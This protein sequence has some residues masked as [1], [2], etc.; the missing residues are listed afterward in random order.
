MNFKIETLTA[1]HIGSSEILSQYSDYVYDNGFVYYIDH[2]LLI[3]ELAKKPNSEDLLDRFISIVKS[4][5][6]ESTS[7]RFR[8]FNFLKE[9]RLD[10]KSC[11]LKKVQVNDEIRVEIQRHINT[12]GQPYIPGSSL[13]GAIRT[14]LICF[15]LSVSEVILRKK[16]YIG[17]DIFG[18][19]GEDVLK[20]LHVSDTTP[21]K[22]ENLAIAKFYK[23]NLESQKRTIPIIKEVIPKGSVSTFYIA[24]KAQKADVTDRFPFLEEG[25]E[26]SLLE[27]I[28]QY[29]TRNIEIEIEQLEKYKSSTTKGL[30][31]FYTELLQEINKANKEAYLRIGF[32][33]TYYYNTI[34]QKL[35]KEVLIN[36]I[37]KTF[38]KANPHFFPK[39]RTLVDE[40]DYSEVPGWVKISKV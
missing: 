16:G 27:M 4:Q 9:T 37:S 24:T 31:E 39:T 8:L 36:T 19:F 6:K 1:V 22:S 13:K 10:Y 23:F 11:A 33:K 38:K 7:D 3:N 20:Y 34:A 5:A 40:G 15:F 2:E 25:K 29:T 21:F 17:E 14:A 26:D 30:I 18:K 28:N 12:S 32:G 35:P